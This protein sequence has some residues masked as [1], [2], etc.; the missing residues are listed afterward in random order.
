MK[1]QIAEEQAKTILPLK[2]A[3]VISFLKNYTEIVKCTDKAES[4]ENMKRLFDVFIKEVIFDGE[5]FLIIMKTTDEPLNPD[6]EQKEEAI[7]KKF[8]LLRFGDPY[9]MAVAS[10]PWWLRHREPAATI[11]L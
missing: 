1:T 4:L 5:R 2:E 11:F 7:R 8:E 3:R 10:L 9:G 6:K